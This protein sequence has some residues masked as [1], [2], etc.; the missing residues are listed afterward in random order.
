MNILILCHGN[1]NRSPLCAEVLRSELPPSC[2]V[3]SAALKTGAR[4]HRAT[5]K[6]RE[7]ALDRGYDLEQHRAHEVARED[8]EWADLVVYMD[9]GNKRR[10][11][12]LLDI[13]GL[14][15]E[16][17]CLASYANEPTTK[18]IPDPNFTPGN[19]EQFQA[20]VDLV[21]KCSKRLSNTIHQ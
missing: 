10:L 16:C 21:I 2:R 14:S 20:V 9:S 7:A 6:M 18:R 17:V 15:K 12:A 4:P 1:L 13:E 8:L 11:D 5:K 3:R 19:S